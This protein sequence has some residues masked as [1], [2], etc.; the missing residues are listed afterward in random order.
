MNIIS[1][2]KELKKQKTNLKT[3][4]SISRSPE[5]RKELENKLIDVE[6]KLYNISNDDA[7]KCFLFKQKKLSELKKKLGI[8]NYYKKD[9]TQL[10]S[11][12]KAIEAELTSLERGIQS[13]SKPTEKVKES[14]SNTYY[15]INLA[16]SGNKNEVIDTVCEFLNKSNYIE[17]LPDQNDQ[18]EEHMIGW[19]YFYESNDEKI[20]TKS[21]YTCASHLL[22]ALK[23]LFH[24][25][26]E[27]FG[28][29]QNY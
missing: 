1:E 16:W 14:H 22:E 5:H 2:Y 27:L 15:S 10:D 29:I 19:K 3:N 4:I 18:R 9:T 20:T 11:T 24:S 6:Q 12:I 23:N 28:K 13:Q 8:Y 25:N 26:A 17:R 21:L 7:V